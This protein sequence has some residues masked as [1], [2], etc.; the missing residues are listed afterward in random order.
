MQ[1]RY[2]LLYLTA[3]AVEEME[4]SIRKLREV[5]A[6]HKET[7]AEKEAEIGCKNPSIFRTLQVLEQPQRPLSW[8]LKVDQSNNEAVL[9]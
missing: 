8:A 4:E 7:M 5:I 3:P 9:G 1:E 6:A 2:S